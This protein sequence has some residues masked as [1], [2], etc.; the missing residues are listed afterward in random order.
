MSELPAATPQA[1]ARPARARRARPE[2]VRGSTRSPTSPPTAGALDEDEDTEER[3]A[4]SIHAAG[5]SALR[6]PYLPQV[7]I[8]L[9]AS[10][11]FEAPAQVLASAVEPRFHGADIGLDGMGDLGQ[12]HAVILGQNHD[13]AL[14]WRQR[15]N[16]QSD[17]L[18]DVAARRIERLSDQRLVVER[19]E[20]M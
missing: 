20:P 11:R 6:R 8:R 3:P 4:P 16:G 13:L 14:Q 12:R 17:Q 15:A 19:F 2:R 7:V 10:Q 18:A 5:D 9:T 1:T